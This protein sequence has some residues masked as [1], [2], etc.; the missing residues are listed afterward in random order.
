MI[1]WLFPIVRQLRG[2]SDGALGSHPESCHVPLI[3]GISITAC[4]FK[5]IP[6]N[7]IAKL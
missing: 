6:A 3:H 5:D 7:T 2:G 4:S 1:G